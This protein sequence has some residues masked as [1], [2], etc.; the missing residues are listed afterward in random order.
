MGASGG[1]AGL[2][3]RDFPKPIIA[4][5]NGSALAGGFEIMLSCD[6]VVAAD[7]ATFGIPEAKR[8]LVAG[9][10]GLIRMPK[11]LPMAVALEL[12]MTGDAHRRRARLSRSGWS[13]RSCPPAVL[14]DEADRAGRADRRQRA[15]GGAL[16]QERHEA[17]RRAPRGR[18][19]DDQRRRQSASSSPRPTPWRG[20]I[21]FAE[22]RAPQLAGQVARPVLASRSTP[23]AHAPRPGGD[24]VGGWPDRHDGPRRPGSRPRRRRPPGA[25]PGLRPH[26]LARLRG[27][28]RHRL[29]EH[30]DLHLVRA[31]HGLE[32]RAH[33]QD[34][35]RR[36]GRAR[37]LLAPAGDHQGASSPSW[38]S[39]AG[40]ASVAGAGHGHPARR[41]DSEHCGRPPTRTAA[42]GNGS[43][44]ESSSP[45]RG[46][47]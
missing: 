10:G 36:P 27:P 18:R 6:L 15:P 42:V 20:P 45:P 40:T 14:L 29:L 41:A 4:A 17:G 32:G 9:A 47:G 7:H 34:R 3:Q 26:G 1:F 11:R 21:A 16:L 8:G 25:G 44:L 46:P 19:L 35:G 43:N 22:K 24:R 37:R 30:L 23:S 5:V 13:T 39:V 28:R 33:R 12:A 2:T 38:G 31:E